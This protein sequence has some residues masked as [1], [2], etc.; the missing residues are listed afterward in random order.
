MVLPNFHI[1]TCA[2]VYPGVASV[3]WQRH[4]SLHRR[5]SIYKSIL[6]PYLLRIGL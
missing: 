3:E 2:V 4:Q 5:F 6:S 1:E